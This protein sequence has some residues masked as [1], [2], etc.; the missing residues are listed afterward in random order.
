MGGGTSPQIGVSGRP[1]GHGYIRISHFVPGRA[2]FSAHRRSPSLRCGRTARVDGTDCFIAYTL[3]RKECCDG[4]SALYL[5]KPVLFR[6]L[7]LALANGFENTNGPIT[8]MFSCELLRRTVAPV[9]RRRDSRANSIDDP[10]PAEP[11]DEGHLPRCG[12]VLSRLPFR[13]VLCLVCGH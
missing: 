11:L 10:P 7:A 6:D 2:I 13:T 9:R 4:F 8:K 12:I 3:A 5:H 1:T